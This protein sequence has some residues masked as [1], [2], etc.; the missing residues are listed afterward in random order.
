LLDGL[1]AIEVFVTEDHS[2]AEAQRIVDEIFIRYYQ[3]D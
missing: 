3:E 1:K 2:Q